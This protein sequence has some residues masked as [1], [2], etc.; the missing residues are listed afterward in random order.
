[1]REK[2]KDKEK[3]IGANIAVVKSNL[4]IMSLNVNCLIMPI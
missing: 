4:S 3:K 2:N 1:M